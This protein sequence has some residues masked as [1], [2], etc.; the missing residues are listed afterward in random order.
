MDSK[1][2]AIGILSTTAAIL[3]VGLV[4][5]HSRPDPVLAAGMTTTSGD[6]VLTVG[7]ATI[8]NEELLY[9]IDAPAEKL[10]AYRFDAARREIVPIE[11]V[12]LKGL[13]E[14]AAAATQQLPPGRQRGGKKRP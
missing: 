7:T 10:I 1:N 6:Y 2:F 14:A 4:I 13:R 12:D 5:I 11:I 8:G 9:I 3:L